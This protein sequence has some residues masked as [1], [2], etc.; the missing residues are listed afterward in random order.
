MEITDARFKKLILCADC[1]KQLNDTK[2]LTAKELWDNWTML[3]LSAGL[4][5]PRCPGGC[6][7]TF[8]DFNIHTTTPVVD[9]NTGKN[10]E[11]QAYKYLMGK[12]YREDYD[13]V[14]DCE[15]R[16]DDEI[17]TSARY[18]AVHGI[19]GKWLEPY[20]DSNLAQSTLTGKEK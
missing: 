9:A 14:C 10:F 8:S 4:N 18:P 19:C 15:N 3:V 5:T 16:Q 20:Q 2:E 6:Q 1:G 11:I 7:P 13:N 12:F 17:Y